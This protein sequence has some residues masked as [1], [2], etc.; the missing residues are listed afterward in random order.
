M[1]SVDISN[2]CNTGVVCQCLPCFPF[3]HAQ[4]ETIAKANPKL[5]TQFQYCEDNM[6]PL[7]AVI[8]QSELEEGVVTLRDM[9]TRAEAKVR[10]S[11]PRAP[12]LL[13]LCCCKHHL[14]GCR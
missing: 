2:F 7:A 9:K 14:R 12:S 8:G 6:I 10:D 13:F 5:L 3:C 11:N 1:L 4:T